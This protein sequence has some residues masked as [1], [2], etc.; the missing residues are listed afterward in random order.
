MTVREL[1]NLMANLDDN[2]I[3][4]TSGVEVAQAVM[5]GDPALIL[6]MD[7]EYEHPGVVIWRD[8]TTRRH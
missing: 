1:K 8:P 5:R 2:A 4:L 6:E 7:P 3:V